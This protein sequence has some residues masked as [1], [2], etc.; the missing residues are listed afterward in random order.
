MKPYAARAMSFPGPSIIIDPIV[1]TNVD[2]ECSNV[3]SEPERCRSWCCLSH[4]CILSIESC[5]RKS[6]TCKKRH[7]KSEGSGE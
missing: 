7:L 3:G 1:F 2:P 5:C 4:E 6:V